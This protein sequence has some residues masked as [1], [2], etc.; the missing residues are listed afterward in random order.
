MK[1]IKITIKSL[2]LD[3]VKEQIEKFNHKAS[4]LN[5]KPLAVTYSSTYIDATDKDDIKELLDITITQHEDV[6]ISN[7]KIIA[8][9][10]HTYPQKNFVKPYVEI[11]T[12][13]EAEWQQIESYCH[14]CNSHRKR[15]FTFI[16]QHTETLE[17][18]QVGKNCLTDFV[19]HDIERKLTYFD[20]L[21]E[22]Q[23]NI[24][25]FNAENSRKINFF[26]I[27][28]VL[29]IVEA[30]IKKN[31]YKSSRAKYNGDV[32]TTTGDDVKEIIK[33]IYSNIDERKRQLPSITQQQEQSF[34]TTIDYILNYDTTKENEGLQDFYNNLKNI[35]KY[36]YCKMKDVAI[37]STTFTVCDILKAKE[38]KEQ[39]KLESN[40]VGAI[41]DKIEIKV[42]LEACFGYD[43]QYGY[44]HINLYK[45]EQGNIYKWNSKNTLD[46][47]KGEYKTIKAT[48]KE[49]E[50]YNGQKQTVITRAKIIE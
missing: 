33:D 13:Q 36:N 21:E 9:I 49:H 14:H 23:F 40:F 29:G 50:E 8:K 17:Y 24:F 12:E 38:L 4:K 32:N 25:N 30:E 28:E 44:M 31:G 10:D 22:L 2:N 16:L 43:T 48:I 19:G 46:I 20:L 37:L 26:K 47:E 7:Y 35:L 27:S 34:K 3:Y 11:T 1:E 41:K 42:T 5:K 45:D 39:Q 18:I 6:I 15:N